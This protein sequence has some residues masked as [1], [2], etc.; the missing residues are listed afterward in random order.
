MRIVWSWL[1]EFCPTEH[2]AESLAERL[3]L[4]GVKVEEVLRPWDGVQGVIV[5]RVVKVE[6]HPNSQKLTVVTV[7]DGTGEHVVCAGIRNNEAGALVPW[8]RPGARVPVLPD[9][10]APRDMGG[11]VSNG[12]LCSAREL[13]I[14]DVHTGI[15]VLNTEAVSPGEDIVT[16][17]GL[18]DE[19][20]DIE[21]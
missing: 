2:T 17:L 10:L 1:Q 18:D 16:A 12:M 14:A 20:L 3:T 6:D 11:V 15:L 13:A 7:D 19:V 4:H 8:A 21:V 5:A 9:P